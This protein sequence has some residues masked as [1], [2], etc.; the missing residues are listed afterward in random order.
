MHAGL[1]RGP[2]GFLH[3]SAAPDPIVL[4]WL[5]DDHF[6][7]NYR[8]KLVVFGHT[9]TEYLTQIADYSLVSSCGTA[10]NGPS[11]FV[12]QGKNGLI[13]EFGNTADSK[14][15]ANGG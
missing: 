8:G 15:N 13:Y 10:G 3:P 9:R 5:R 1:P 7:R 2:Q 14:A 11:Y 6:F 4:L 12:V